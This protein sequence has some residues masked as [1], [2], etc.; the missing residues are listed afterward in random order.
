MKN[1]VKR[2][3]HAAQRKASPRNNAMRKGALRGRATSRS[4]AV[5]RKNAVTRAKSVPNRVKKQAAVSAVPVVKKTRI[6]Q[7][8]MM[9]LHSF[10]EVAAAI[11]SI[12]SNENAANYLKKNV[13]KRTMDVINKLA[14]P[15]TDEALAEE[16]GMKINA[17]RRILNILQGYG[18]TN[19]YVAKNVNGWLSFAWYVNVSKLP[20]FFE[21]VNSV[22]NDRPVVNENCNDYFIC[23]GCYEKTKL[24]FTF[25]AAFEDNFKCTSC[26]RG[27]KMMDRVQV[28][29]MVD[30]AAAKERAAAQLGGG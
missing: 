12:S 1:S 10:E 11:E 21:Y 26:G 5:A 14:V 13:S 16:L 8:A 25:D 6:R 9:A 7:D 30:T 17:V 4:I 22:E 3:G 23:N 29:E 27:L 28:T 24:V 18:V 19:Y 20:P 15:K 2:K